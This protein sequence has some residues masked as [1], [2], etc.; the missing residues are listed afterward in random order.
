MTN[1]KSGWEMHLMNF[2][3]VMFFCS[4]ILS[5]SIKNKKYIYLSFIFALLATFTRLDGIVLLPIAFI[6][7]FLIIFQINKKLFKDLFYCFL[8]VFFTFFLWFFSVASFFYMNGHVNIERGKL[9]TFTKSLT[10]LSFNHQTG[11]QLYWRFLMDVKGH[12]NAL[13]N[14]NSNSFEQDYVTNLLD[15][16][17]GP[18]SKNLYEKLISAYEDPLVKKFNINFYKDK[19]LP[20][21]VSAKNFKGKDY[22]NMTKEEIWFDHYGQYENSP[23]KFADAVF[24]ENTDSVYYIL[25]VPEILAQHLGRIETNKLLMGVMKE[26]SSNHSLIFKNIFSSFLKSYSINWNYM[27]EDISLFIYPAGIAWYNSIPFNGG[28]CPKNDL[29]QNMFEEYE[30]SFNTKVFIN[31]SYSKAL[32]NYI[33]FTR[34]LI[35]N[36]LAPITLLFILLSLIPKYSLHKLFIFSSAFAYFLNSLLVSIFATTTAFKVESYTFSYLFVSLFFII[37]ISKNFKFR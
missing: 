5:Y 9:N 20:M 11:G 16:N 32:K 10:S 25:H 33:N 23:E 17:N 8:I 15:K 28:N 4:L 29:P 12:H 13:L 21:M 35:R 22:H 14:S 19:M 34:D 7:N 26:T 6:S 30:S 1:I 31:N 3:V 24:S 2:F 37:I 27:T 18:Y 36:L